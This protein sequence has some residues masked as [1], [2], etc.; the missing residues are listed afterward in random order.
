MERARCGI[1]TISPLG[2]DYFERLRQADHRVCE[3]AGIMLCLLV[4]VRNSATFFGFHI[5]S[6]KR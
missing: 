6:V 5:C 3:T 2:V 4:L 1:T